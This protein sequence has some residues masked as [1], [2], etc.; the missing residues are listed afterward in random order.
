MH[1]E[2]MCLRN[3]CGGMA[4]DFC[5]GQHGMSDE[6]WRGQTDVF[7]VSCKSWASYSCV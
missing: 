6:A 1:K 7:A 4:L 2:G 5:L 3:N